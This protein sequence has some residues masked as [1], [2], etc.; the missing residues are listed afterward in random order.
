MR[1]VQL[2]CVTLAGLALTGAVSAQ[3]RCNSG[4]SNF[5][6]SY[7]NGYNGYHQYVPAGA[8][9]P[10]YNAN[11]PVGYQSGYSNNGYS[12]NG[13]CNSNRNTGYNNGYNNGNRWNNA[14][15]YYGNNQNNTNQ[16]HHHRRH[17][18]NNGNNGN[19]NNCR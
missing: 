11:L 8:G 13:S 2:A 14:N 10:Y 12:N 3:P 19:S 17:N 7:N 16:G 5:N 18:G 4:N 6:Y 1:I 15:Y 9:Q